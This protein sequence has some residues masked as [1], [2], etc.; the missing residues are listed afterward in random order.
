MSFHPSVRLLQNDSSY[1]TLGEI[2]DQYCEEINVAREDASFVIGEKVKIAMQEFK[3]SMGRAVCDILLCDRAI[4]N[5]LH[6]A[7]QN[8]VLDV[9]EGHV[10]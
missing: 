4:A 7:Y 1:V 9:E 8:R 3:Q 2:Y 10:R 5:I 6:P